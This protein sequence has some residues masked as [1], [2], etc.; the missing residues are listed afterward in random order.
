M[1]PYEIL[2]VDPQQADD[3]IVRR[4]YLELVRR[5]PPD[6]FPD[7]FQAIH[8]A[9]EQLKDERSRLE[10]YL[11]DRHPGISLP[12]EVLREERGDAGEQSRK[13]PDFNHLQRY[14]RQWMSR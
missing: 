5:Y 10:Y 2:A 11:F 13:P 14:L 6:R 9:Y 12:F 4:A 7:R 8:A 3:Q 1:T